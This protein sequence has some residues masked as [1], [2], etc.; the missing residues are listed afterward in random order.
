MTPEEKDETFA[1]FEEIKSGRTKQLIE[2]VLKDDYITAREI[3]KRMLQDDSILNE[4]TKHMTQDP[5]FTRKAAV[6]LTRARAQAQF[7]VNT[8]PTAWER[9]LEE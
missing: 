4:V 5:T 8:A 6:E 1:I 2:A 9:I 3:A 7:A